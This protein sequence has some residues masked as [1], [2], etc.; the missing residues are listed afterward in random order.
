MTNCEAFVNSVIVTVIVI[1]IRISCLLFL[2]F[3][4]VERFDE[5]FCYAF[6]CH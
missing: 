1:V 2:R 5:L 4:S 6:V 3:R